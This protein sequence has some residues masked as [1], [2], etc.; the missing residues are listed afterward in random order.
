MKKI[1]IVFASLFLVGCG[2]KFT[3][4]TTVEEED[5]KTQEKIVFEFDKNDRIINATVDYIMIF[6]DEEKAGNYMNILKTLDKELEIELEGNEIKL[7]TTKDYEEYDEDKETLKS[8]LEKDGYIC[9]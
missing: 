6:E 9:K 4:T 8:E 2:N 1:L 5:Y 3:C 7:S